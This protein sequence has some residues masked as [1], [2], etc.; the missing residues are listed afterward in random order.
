MERKEKEDIIIPE[1]QR[2]IISDQ[3]QQF[4]QQISEQ[5]VL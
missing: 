5:Y 3:I 2:R 4:G 1:H